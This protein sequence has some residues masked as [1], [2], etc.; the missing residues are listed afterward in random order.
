MRIKSS[1]QAQ[2]S[3]SYQCLKRLR[4]PTQKFETGHWANYAFDDKVILL[5][6]TIQI[7]TMADSELPRLWTKR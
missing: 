2:L 3:C 4:P 1:H 7:C 6:N 5:H